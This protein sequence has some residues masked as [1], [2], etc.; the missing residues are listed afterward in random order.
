MTFKPNVMHFIKKLFI[1]NIQ[2]N[3]CHIFLA[4]P[5]LANHNFAGIFKDT[6]RTTKVK[7]KKKVV[8]V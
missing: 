1:I 7:W 3:K 8:R 6:T 2:N 5:P 4:I